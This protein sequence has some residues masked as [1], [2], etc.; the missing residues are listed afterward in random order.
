MTEPINISLFGTFWAAIVYMLSMFYG[1]LIVYV[2]FSF[3]LSGH[4]VV[5]RENAK[6]WL[7][8][9][10]IMIV[11]VQASFFIYQLAIEIS[12]LMTAAVFNLIDDE[13]FLLSADSFTEISIQ[14]INSIS[15]LT[16]LILTVFLSVMRYIFVCIGLIFFP[17]GIFLSFIPPLKG[18][19]K[20]ILNVIGVLILMTFFQAILLLGPSM[21]LEI[22]FFGNLS[23]IVMTCAFLL[24][25]IMFFILLWLAMT[26]SRSEAGIGQSLRTIANLIVKVG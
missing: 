10:I 17:I 25:D 21:I 19:G 26:W 16:V 11:L 8:N 3:M 23:S 18:Y 5:K 7:K 9:I 20:F 13:I 14:L 4:D 24:S 15:Y 1:L 2:G 22:E 12:S 6:S